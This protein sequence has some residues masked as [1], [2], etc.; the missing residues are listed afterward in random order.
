M[1]CE[2]RRWIRVTVLV[3]MGGLLVCSV[4]ELVSGRRWAAAPSA[5]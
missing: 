3:C 5:A 4:S 1:G 2:E